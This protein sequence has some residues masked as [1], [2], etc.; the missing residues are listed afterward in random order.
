MDLL[1]VYNHIGEKEQYEK[2][3]PRVNKSD[4]VKHILVSHHW[5]V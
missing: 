1:K 4:N 3:L 2:G 5:P